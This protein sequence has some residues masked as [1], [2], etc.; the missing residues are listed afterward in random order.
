MA[1][2]VFLMLQ[3]KFI[4]R[5]EG[6]N[7]RELRLVISYLPI[8]CPFYTIFDK[9]KI[10][11]EGPGPTPHSPS[12]PDTSFGVKFIDINVLPVKFTQNYSLSKCSK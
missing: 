12:A 9:M 11:N 3:I 7:A 2:D 4:I 10:K 1:R 5:I 6:E 8:M